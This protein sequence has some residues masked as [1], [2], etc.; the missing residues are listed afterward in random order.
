LGGIR[1]LGGR[2]FTPMTDAEITAL[3][4]RLG[5][6]LSKAYRNFLATYGASKFKG[7]SPDNPY[8][9]FRSLSPFPPHITTSNKALFAAFYGGGMDEHDT[10]SLQE[11]SR[12]FAGRMPD[13]ITSL[14]D[15]SPFSGFLPLKGTYTTSTYGGSSQRDSRTREVAEC[16]KEAGG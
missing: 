16:V 6:R 7:A 9:V 4:E 3:E 12:F 1:P 14:H 8:I 15:L 2:E 5:G 10:Y 13:T 11:R